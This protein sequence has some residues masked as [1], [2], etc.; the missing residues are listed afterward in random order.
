MRSEW[1]KSW[2][3]GN[4]S[5]DSYRKALKNFGAFLFFGTVSRLANKADVISPLEWVSYGFLISA[6]P[7]GVIGLM[8]K[9]SE[10]YDF[11]PEGKTI[12]LESTG[13]EIEIKNIHQAGTDDG[14]GT[15]I[16]TEFG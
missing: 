7:Q 6:F 9:L 3:I 14:D 4:S 16:L 2:L 11:L 8:R 10:K 13:Q 1:I 15:V 12:G 5:E